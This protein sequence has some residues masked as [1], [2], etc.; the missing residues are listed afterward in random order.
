MKMDNGGERCSFSSTLLAHIRKK[1]ALC[2]LI[3]QD[4]S[5]TGRTETTDSCRRVLGHRVTPSVCSSAGTTEDLRGEPSVRPRALGALRSQNECA[6]SL[7]VGV[8]F[9]SSS[10]H[11]PG[12]TRSLFRISSQLSCERQA[13]ALNQ[14]LIFKY[15]LWRGV[16]FPGGI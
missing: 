9:Y 6:K 5:P 7:Q 16:V 4:V 8:G 15:T 3:A 14:K 10:K 11:C 13:H 2:W 12:Y 1:A